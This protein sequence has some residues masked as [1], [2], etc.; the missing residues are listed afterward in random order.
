MRRRAVREVFGL[1]EDGFGGGPAELGTLF[2]WSVV[3]L[4][5]VDSAHRTVALLPS[6]KSS[7][8][9]RGWSRERAEYLSLTSTGIA[10]ALARRYF[11]LASTSFNSHCDRSSKIHVS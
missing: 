7:V 8:E 6:S 9:R 11:T 10:V 1:E 2:G 5:E 4:L 3:M